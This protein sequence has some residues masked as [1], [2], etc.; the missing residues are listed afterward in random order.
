MLA[1]GQ[2]FSKAGHYKLKIKQNEEIWQSFDVPPSSLRFET[3]VIRDQTGPDL[4]IGYSIT[5]NARPGMEQL[6]NSGHGTFDTVVHAR[7]AELGSLSIN[8]ADAIALAVQSKDLI[9]DYKN[10][11]QATRIHLIVV[12][13]AAYVLFLGQYLNALGEI[14]AYEFVNSSYVPAVKLFA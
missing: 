3:E 5:T 8:N 2:I 12:G 14:I 13:P 10:H 11:Y 9:R 7:L 4:L 6:I 1:V